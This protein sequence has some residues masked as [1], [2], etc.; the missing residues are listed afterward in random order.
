M[1]ESKSPSKHAHFD[2]FELEQYD[3]TRGQHQKIP[4]PKTPY[5]DEEPEEMTNEKLE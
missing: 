1:V 3:K 4:D 5:I 2:E